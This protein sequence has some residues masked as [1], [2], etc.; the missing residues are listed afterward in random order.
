MK[1]R[2]GLQS[3]FHF[4]YRYCKSHDSCLR[5]SV[6]N[7]IDYVLKRPRIGSSDDFI[8]TAK[9]I[10]GLTQSSGVGNMLSLFRCK[11]H[12]QKVRWCQKL[13]LVMRTV[14]ATIK[15]SREV[16]QW[17]RCYTK[18]ACQAV[19]C[20]PQRG[21]IK[22]NGQQRDGEALIAQDERRDL[23]ACLWIS[24]QALWG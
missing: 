18:F 14:S 22:K 16:Y 17:Y 7:S 8:V 4:A 21:G 23:G 1:S 20:S 6:C 2:F 19:C 13:A 5:S 15:G 24:C 10:Q 12:Y 3:A 9:Q 11:Q